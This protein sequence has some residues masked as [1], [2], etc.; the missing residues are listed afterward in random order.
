MLSIANTIISVLVMFAW[1][2]LLL[3]AEEEEDNAKKQG[4]V[5]KGE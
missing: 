2:L 4:E 3:A 1:V 5:M